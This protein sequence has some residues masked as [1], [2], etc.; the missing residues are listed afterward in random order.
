M[1]WKLKIS[2]LS[3]R[4]HYL[5]AVWTFLP[6]F[7]IIVSGLV[8]QVKKEFSWIQPPTA[9]GSSYTMEVSLDQILAAAQGVEQ[10]S[11]RSWEDVDRLDIRPSKGVVKIRANNRWEV[12]VSSA[13]AAVLHVAYRR[14]DLIESIHDGSFF[15]D[16]FRLGLFL[17]AALLLLGLWLTGV[18]MFGMQWWNKRGVKRKVRL[19]E[20]A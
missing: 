2:R 7:I 12:Q 18:I 6:V 10:A 5:A 1:R 4:F 14:S 16:N 9:K 17:P 13:N 20:E 19:R 15:H 3:R 11:I 8:L